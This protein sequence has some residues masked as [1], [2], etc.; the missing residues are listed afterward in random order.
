[1]EFVP[2]IILVLYLFGLLAIGI[3]SLLKGRK[4]EHTEEDYYLSSRGQGVL[5]T[6]LTIMATY[7]S[8]FAI[9]A[10]PGWV[11][12]NG[13]SPML[14]ALNLPVAAMAIYILGNRIRRIGA[15]RGYITPA[16]MISD[17]YG[18]S[19][20]IRGLVALIG[21]L[22]VIPYVVMQ[23]K[24]GGILAQGLFQDVESVVV[25]GQVLTIEHAGV[26]ALSLVT[27]AYVI[28]GGM[29]SVAWTD[30]IQGILLLSAMLLSGVAI[31]Y[32]LGGPVGYFT[33]I[34]KLDGNLLVIPDAPGKFNTWHAMTFCMFASL[35]SI[36]QPAQWMR[37]YAARDS[38]T[39]RRTSISFATILPVC[40]IFGV[41][42][43]GLGGRALYPMLADG[44]LPEEL[45]KPDD[46]VIRV[47]QDQFPMMFG[48]VGVILV[49]LILVAV[50]AASMST[51]DSNLHALSAVATRDVYRPLRP[52]AG[53]Q[54][55]TWFGRGVIVITTIVAT[56]ITFAGSQSNLLDTI[57][58]FFLLAMAFSAQLLPVTI[59]LLFL[60]R[61][62][63]AGAIAGMVVGILTVCLFP[64]LGTLLL[65]ADSGLISGTGQVKAILD[66][67][68]CGLVINA[69]V[70]ALVTRFTVKPDSAH[71][72]AFARD[73]IK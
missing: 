50:M 35:A 38:A 56:L 34:G 57:T 6:S 69:L 36:V 62:S 21:A 29:R 11:Y 13:I 68:F 30:V 48:A 51:A 19:K 67:G 16:D 54:E 52:K 44:S 61:G 1:M 22:Y 14:Y 10:F 40:F 58:A 31:M 12:G 70:F 27:M 43:V 73:L 33:E 32:A 15:K 60:R 37:F 17:Y 55:R 3:I 4:A 49:S 8:G 41:F 18:E 46:I 59:D 39:L 47:I 25:F 65:G 28:V 66:V 9:L 24:A 2:H 63:K 71:R 72:E 42:L 7:F 26:G 20:S 45:R 23:V 5:V 53:E 64:P